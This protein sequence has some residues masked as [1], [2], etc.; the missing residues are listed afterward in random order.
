MLQTVSRLNLPTDAEQTI[1]TTIRSFD[2]RR[3]SLRGAGLGPA[4]NV[5]Q[6]VSSQSGRE[7]DA[8]DRPWVQQPSVFRCVAGN[9]SCR[10]HHCGRGSI[11]ERACGQVFMSPPVHGAASCCRR[12]TSAIRQ[13]PDKAG[14]MSVPLPAPPSRP[15]ILRTSAFGPRTTQLLPAG[16]QA[17]VSVS[18]PSSTVGDQLSQELEDALAEERALL[19][20]ARAA[21]TLYL[22]GVSQVKSERRNWFRVGGLGSAAGRGARGCEPT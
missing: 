17:S 14:A 18:V 6:T 5:I 2:T 15:S 19:A 3:P 1:H 21:G 22:F 9:G 16:G 4:I 20:K 10:S 7:G 12:V 8:E 13:V 11:R